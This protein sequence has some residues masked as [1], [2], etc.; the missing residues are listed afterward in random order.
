MMKR[1]IFPALVL[2]L[3]FTAIAGERYIAVIPADLQ[4]T[5]QQ[6]IPGG[7]W[8]VELS[9]TGNEPPT[10]YW[11]NW[12]GMDNTTRLEIIALGGLVY[13]GSV[14]SPDEVLEDLNLKRI[15]PGF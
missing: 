5:F 8:D 13:N 11:C 9:T 6:Q 15:K 7:G 1:L 3:A 2:L 12:A 10:H 14:W 4:E